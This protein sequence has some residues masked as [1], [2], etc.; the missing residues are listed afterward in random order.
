MSRPIGV[1]L[2]A[3]LLLGSSLWAGYRALTLQGGHRN[4]A[5][6]VTSLLLVLL[7]LVAADALWSLRPHAFVAFVAWGLCAMV[8]LAHQRLRF[9]AGAHGGGI[10]TDLVY[11]GLVL[12]AAALYLRRA[13]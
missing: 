13:V 12:A 6:L 8:A 11:A 9:P 3:T 1:T 4:H 10:I 2:I 5:L 7:A